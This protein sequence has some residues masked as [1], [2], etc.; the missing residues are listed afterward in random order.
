[1]VFSNK[2][3]SGNFNFFLQD[4]QL[5]DLLKNLGLTTAELS[6]L[7]KNVEELKRRY[8]TF[9]ILYSRFARLTVLPT[10]TPVV[11]EDIED[12]EEENNG[13]NSSEP[14]IVQVLDSEEWNGFLENINFDQSTLTLQNAL[15]FPVPLESRCAE[16]LFEMRQCALFMGK[17]W[18][19]MVKS[20]RR[21]P[22]RKAGL[23]DFVRECSDRW[24]CLARSVA[25]GTSTFHEMEEIIS[26]QDNPNVLSRNHLQSESITGVEVAY[27]NFK[28]LQ[29]IRHLIGPFVSAL[30]FFSIK[31]RAPID[32]LHNFVET[33]LL[34][35]WHDT[36]L[37]EVAGILQLVNDELNID[38]KR[39]ETRN[40]MQFIGSL[41]T[42]GNRS[43]LI[44]WLRG[45]TEKDMD[46]MGKFLQ[47]ALLE[48]Y[49]N[50]VFTTFIFLNINLLSF[51]RSTPD[52]QNS[53]CSFFAD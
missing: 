38:P 3:V 4:P 23:L 39:P 9:G 11:A 40:A 47:G 37:A 41:V 50:F 21:F 52:T 35:N 15:D 25:D 28:N 49:G 22:L 2:I 42:D 46:A 29:E 6:Q 31:N 33:N 44:E 53:N 19:P 5:I 7:H 51:I 10:I 12:D 36:T 14:E 30:R 26:L 48:V 43:P 8:N 20:I 13:E 17:V 45:K 32:E 16:W 27:W 24:I 34:E 18:H 1:M